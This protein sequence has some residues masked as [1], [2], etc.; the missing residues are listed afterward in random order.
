MKKISLILAISAASAQASAL[1]YQLTDADTYADL[2]DYS[3][4]TFVSSGAS[5]TFSVYLES[6]GSTSYNQFTYSADWTFTA[7]NG[8]LTAQNITCNSLDS[9]FFCD[10]NALGGLQNE[11]QLVFVDVLDTATQSPLFGATTSAFDLSWNGQRGSVTWDWQL[12]FSPQPVPVP[13]AAWLFGSALVGL[14]GLKRK[15]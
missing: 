1:T 3:S 9:A 14:A 5:N 6:V 11:N 8:T 12:T 15:Q 2:T 7:Y 13:A 10:S 4:S